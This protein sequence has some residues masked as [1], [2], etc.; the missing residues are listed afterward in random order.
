ML[1]E[2]QLLKDN[3]LKDGGLLCLFTLDEPDYRIKGNKAISRTCERM[4]NNDKSQSVQISKNCLEGKALYD[5][6]SPYFDG[7]L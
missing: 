3:L 7:L 5:L 6:L 2:E 4:E 1:L